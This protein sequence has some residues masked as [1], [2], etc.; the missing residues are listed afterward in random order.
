ME[1]PALEFEEIN[2]IHSMNTTFRSRDT[3]RMQSL[4]IPS[5]FAVSRTSGPYGELWL[6]ESTLPSVSHEASIHK[7]TL[8][9]IEVVEIIKFLAQG[10]GD[11]D[12][13]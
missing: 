12:M 4:E 6:N 8:I 1:L 10:S 9:Q 2:S 5:S 7:N 13:N 11:C 3:C